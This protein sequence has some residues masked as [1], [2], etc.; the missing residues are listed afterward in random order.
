MHYPLLGEKGENTTK[1][2]P[3]LLQMLGT[4]SDLHCPHTW[5]EDKLHSSDITWKSIQIWIPAKFRTFPGWDSTSS[6]VLQVETK[7]K[8]NMIA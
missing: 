6:P 8:Q 4:Y 1:V 7:R 3:S 2:M 5:Q